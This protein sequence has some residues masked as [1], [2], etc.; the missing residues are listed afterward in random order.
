M[1]K[2]FSIQLILVRHRASLHYVLAQRMNIML[3]QE[4]SQFSSPAGYMAWLF[5]SNIF[6]KS[7]C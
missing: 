5:S 2:N 3:Q 4:A 6:L 7:A 1:K